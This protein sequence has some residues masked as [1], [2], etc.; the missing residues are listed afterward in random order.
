MMET[1]KFFELKQSHPRRFKKFSLLFGQAEMVFVKVWFLDHFRLNGFWIIKFVSHLHIWVTKFKPSLMF[2]QLPVLT[3]NN[4][5]S[6]A[7]MI[8]AAFFST[9]VPCRPLQRV[10]K[11]SIDSHNV[12]FYCIKG[13]WHHRR[14]LFHNFGTRQGHFLGRGQPIMGVFETFFVFGIK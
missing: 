8:L 10:S 14:H 5:I 9:A 7:F 1:T 2:F 6:L 13:K 4:D 12:Q 11:V 3:S